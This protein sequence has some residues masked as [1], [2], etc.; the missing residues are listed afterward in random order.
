MS[1]AARHTA[2]LIVS[3]IFTALI[4]YGFSVMLSWFFTPDQFGV[5]GVAQSLLLVTALAVGSGFAWI[6][7]QDLAIAGPTDKTRRRFRAAWI[8]NLFLGLLL[9]GGIWFAYEVGLLSLGAAYAGIIP[10]VGLTTLLLA[11]RAVVNGAARGLYRFGS[12][13]VN[14]VLDAVL[15]VL[16]GLLLV[17]VGAGVEGVILAASLATAATTLH[18]LWIVRPTRLWSG[19]G[20]FDHRIWRATAPFFLGIFGP[21]LIMNLDILGLKLFAPAGQGDQLAGF[22]QAAI[23][24]ARTPVFVAQSLTL[25]LFSYVSGSV[26]A[27][28]QDALD[29]YLH[30][31]MRLW[32][33]LLLPG[34][35]VLI[36]FPRLVL[37]LFFPSY[38]SISALPLR[39]AAAG[40]LLLALMTMFNGV[41]QAAGNRR[42]PAYVAGASITLQVA[43]LAILVPRWGAIGAAVSLLA[44]ASL[45]VIGLAPAIQPRA[46]L[47][48]DR[49]NAETLQ[50]IFRNMLPLLAMG[51]CLLLFPDGERSIALLKLIAAGGTYLVTLISIHLKPGD[52]LD[53]PG[54]QI[55]SRFVNV[56]LGG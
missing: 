36:L 32:L 41:F 33:R 51:I 8:A 55:M 22:Y 6:P 18:S 50:D 43:V 53:R 42:L 5:L 49:P 16:I 12:V 30:V 48:L 4:N 24:L 14:M 37:G 44:G 13:A 11:A 45:G 27:S 34:A 17:Y 7:A 3:F 25:V 20:W 56:F 54:S 35:L 29:S 23:I 19:Q 38:Y 1:K 47:A 39:I 46:R 9:A 2:F 31:V 21:A 40:G 26:N 10:L 28:S 52:P 15:K